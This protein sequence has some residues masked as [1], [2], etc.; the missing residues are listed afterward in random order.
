MQEF[1]AVLLE[2]GGRRGNGRR[3]GKAGGLERGHSAVGLAR[4]GWGD[5]IF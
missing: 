5:S 4:A 1:F 2:K 3:R